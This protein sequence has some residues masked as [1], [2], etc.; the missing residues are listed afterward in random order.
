MENVL[1]GLLSKSSRGVHDFFLLF[2]PSNSGLVENDL[3]VTSDL[4]RTVLFADLF[5]FLALPLYP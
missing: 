1:G 5:V 3:H 2:V 4:Y